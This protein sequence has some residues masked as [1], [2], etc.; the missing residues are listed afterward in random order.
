MLVI[1]PVALVCV[2]AHGGL[3][4]FDSQG[5]LLPEDLRLALLDEDLESL[6]HELAV[7]PIKV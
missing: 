3:E 5:V 4:E 1:R 6:D 2:E 7:E